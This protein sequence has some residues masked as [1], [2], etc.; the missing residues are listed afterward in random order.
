MHALSWAAA[1]RGRLADLGRKRSLPAIMAVSAPIIVAPARR[2]GAVSGALSAVAGLLANQI[3]DRGEISRR[4]AL[5]GEFLVDLRR[6]RTER[7]MGADRLRRV[8][9]QLQVLQH[10]GGG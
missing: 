1:N 10:Q 8:L 7:G 6:M 4:V 9:A 3:D 2:G 5:L